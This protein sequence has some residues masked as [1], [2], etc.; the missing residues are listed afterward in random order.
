M[1]PMSLSQ[2][3]YYWRSVQC[4]GFG[5]AQMK[6]TNTVGTLGKTSVGTILKGGYNYW[7]IL[8]LPP[9][10]QM[11][12]FDKKR[13][14][15]RFPLDTKRHL[16][17]PK[18]GL[19]GLIPE[20]GSHWGKCITKIWFL[21]RQSALLF[22]WSEKGGLWV[23]LSPIILTHSSDDVWCLNRILFFRLLSGFIVS[24]IQR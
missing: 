1:S 18:L 22:M 3:T 9:Y 13:H 6:N 14:V 24:S 21:F 7:T 19:F 10:L 11:S 20:G 12:P 17:Y 15:H 2:P 23:T 16:I 8:P 5:P 4:I